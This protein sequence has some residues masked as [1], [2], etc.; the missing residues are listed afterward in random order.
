[1]VTVL[2]LL[3]AQ[4]AEAPIAPRSPT[5]PPLICRESERQTGSHIRTGPRCMT[6][7][8]WMRED[9]RRARVPASLRV[10]EG[11]GDELTKPRSQ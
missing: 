5:K 6:A 1:M 3:A 2:M 9:E 8:Q 7:E 11:Q 10:T 4:A